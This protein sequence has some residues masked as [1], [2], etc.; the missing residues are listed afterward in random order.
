MLPQTNARLT[1]I[2]GAGTAADWD[3]PGAAGA[4]KWSGDADAYYSEKRERVYRGGDTDL[5]LRR[6]L[7]VES[8]FVDQLDN[9]DLV[10]FTYQGAEQS[11]AVKLIERRDLEDMPADLRTTRLTLADA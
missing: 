2:A 7:I 9:D 8:R 1:R 11:A 10:T 3:L 5:V 4:E 6:T